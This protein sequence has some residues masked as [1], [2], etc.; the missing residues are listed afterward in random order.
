MEA[1]R[2]DRRHRVGIW[3][4]VIERVGMEIQVKEDGSGNGELGS[5]MDGR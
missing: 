1:W 4:D 5:S 3:G 2:G